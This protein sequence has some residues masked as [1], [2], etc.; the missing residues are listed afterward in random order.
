MS[1]NRILQILGC[2]SGVC[3]VEAIREGATPRQGS[4]ALI[5]PLDAV[6][7]RPSSTRAHIKICCCS[8]AFPSQVYRSHHQRRL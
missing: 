8:L 5:R 1:L 6:W 7:I 2:S 3:H 4:S